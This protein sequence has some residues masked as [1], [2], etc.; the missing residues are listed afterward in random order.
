MLVESQRGHLSAGSGCGIRASRA[1]SAIELGRA[2]AA[3]VALAADELLGKPLA[4][5][6]AAV[7]AAGPTGGGGASPPPSLALVCWPCCYTHAYVTDQ[8][9]EK[10][11]KRERELSMNIHRSRDENIVWIFEPNSL[12]ISRRT[13]VGL[14]GSRFKAS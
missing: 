6:A 2:C 9:N 4:S 11:R 1:R 14:D 12:A 7:G 10:S 3:T 13:C 8:H 5:G